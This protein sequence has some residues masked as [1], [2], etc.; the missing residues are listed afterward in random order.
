MQK[1]MHEFYCK[2]CDYSCKRK[3]LWEQHLA[4][5]KHNR[6][7][8]ATPK[9]KKTKRVEYEHICDLCGKGY[10]Q[11]SGL[12]RHKK[13]C[14]EIEKKYKPKIKITIN[15]SDDED[16]ENKVIKNLESE[17]CELKTLMEKMMNGLHNDT[18]IK[19]EMMEQM[20]EQSK[21]IQDMIP[22]IGNNNNNRFNI[23]VFLNEQCKN[24]INLSDFIQSLQIQ[25]DDL[26]YTKD[27]GLIEGVS[28]VFVNALNQLDTFHRPI[29]C[30]DIKRETLYIKENNEWERD[31]NKE[32]IK[33]AIT[34]IANKQR[35]TIK[36]WE[37]AHPN[38]EGTDKGRDEYIKIVQTA[39]KDVSDSPT[40]NK[41][42]KNIVK[43][44]VVSK[45]ILSDK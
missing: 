4:T 27:K 33:N 31:D 17:N 26:I 34:D 12:W 19:N 32:H 28:N 18:K 45:E 44:T 2:K 3:F 39:M 20:K 14:C 42:I 29:H 40:E 38:W 21:I 6:Q 23:N 11:R 25:L 15:S 35:N 41:I 24:A 43:E 22:R 13:N 16:E 30:T 1:N 36:E 5:Q 37:D 9:I 7:R 10:K 8:Q